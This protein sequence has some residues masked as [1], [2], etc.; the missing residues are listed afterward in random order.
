MLE[1]PSARPTGAVKGP[2][3]GGVWPGAGFT[4]PWHLTRL[5]RGLEP[6]LR[7]SVSQASKQMKT[8]FE[9]EFLHYLLRGPLVGTRA[10]HSASVGPGLLGKAHSHIWGLL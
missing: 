6:G 1:G 5:P 10:L 2:K 8:A 3:A 7:P 4:L 9:W